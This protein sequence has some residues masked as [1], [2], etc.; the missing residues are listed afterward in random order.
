MRRNAVP[1]ILLLMVVLSLSAMAHSTL[2]HITSISSVWARPYQTIQIAGSGFGSMKPYTGDSPFIAVTDVTQNWNAGHSGDG[3]TL[4]VSSWTNSLI[5]IT[6]FS[7]AY[8]TGN[9]EILAGDVLSFEIW[10]PQTDA[11]PG[12]GR[13][14][15]A[16]ANATGIYSFQGVP[17]P[18]APDG[19]I[20]D[21]A[22]NLYGFSGQ[23]GSN[24]SCLYGGGCG[25]VIDLSPGA[26]G[27]WSETSL[28]NFQGGTTD[29]W[30]V[31]GTPVRD[32]AGNLYGVT[33]WGGSGPC[34][35]GCGIV[36]EITGNTETILH[37]F[38]GGNSDG[39]WPTAGLTMD[40]SGNLYGTTTYGGSAADAGT[41][42]ELSPD[43]GGGFSYS[44]VYA[45]QGG[46]HDGAV[47]S[48]S[49]TLDAAGNIYGT[50]YAGGSTLL[51]NDDTYR[52]G[53]GTVFEMSPASGGG[54]TERII[55]AFR[56]PSEGMRPTSGLTFDAAGSLFG[57][58]PGGGPIC[59]GR[60][61][62]CGV[63]Y[64]LTPQ[65]NGTWEFSV[66][67]N[68]TSG[69]G[70][71]APYGNLALYNG[72]FYGYAGGGVS[73]VGTI[74]TMTPTGDGKFTEN[75]FYSF[76]G[77]SDGAGGIGAPIFGANGTLYGASG[78]GPYNRGVAFTY[79]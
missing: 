9:L 13:S 68:F 43:G 59:N 39:N 1:S 40:S 18:N 55:Y 8:G 56:G 6:A 78:E 15:A 53:C 74:Y 70:A 35:F 69:L 27:V 47:P 51:C 28:Y 63:F 45:F 79:P 31:V 24:S 5:S 22:G 10:N 57:V 76:S 49:L 75:A 60:T 4:V 14:A 2:P 48:S 46:A 7:G 20:M 23:G 66:Y 34:F 17:N 21:E 72:V 30:G 61:Y 65:P 19:F 26:G 52:A 37:T 50:T 38:Q 44:V 58:T 71:T 25:A 41:V 67:Y 42:F 73:G 64:G 29:G 32:S 12:K 3:V 36:F 33:Y 62:G 16:L 54:W 77:G 11:G